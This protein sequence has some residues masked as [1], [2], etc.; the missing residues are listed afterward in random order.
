MTFAPK[1]VTPV[2]F[3]PKQGVQGLGYRGLDPGLA[4]LG[5][6]SA[7]HIDLFKPQSD[8]RS[9]LFGEARGGSRR[10]GVAGQVRTLKSGLPLDSRF[11]VTIC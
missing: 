11:V 5:R 2:D 4:L 9:Q 7:D 10:G 1:D 6:G 3:T 8:M